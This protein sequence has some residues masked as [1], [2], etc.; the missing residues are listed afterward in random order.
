MSPN[1]CGKPSTSEEQ[2]TQIHAAP[3]DLA[4]KFAIASEN[5]QPI[6]MFS[7]NS[8]WEP[9]LRNQVMENFTRLFFHLAWLNH[10]KW[11]MRTA[12][13]K[14]YILYWCSLYVCTC[15]KIMKLVLEK[16]NS[17]TWNLKKQASKKTQ[18]HTHS[19]LRCCGL[20]M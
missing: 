12:Q 20:L 19:H 1:A 3:Y 5:R 7:H 4:L 18:H 13:M 16:I 14:L 10:L 15:F 11:S 8:E 2:I 9:S 17:G 6:K